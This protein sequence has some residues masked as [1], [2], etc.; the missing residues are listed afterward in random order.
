MSG[1][2]VVDTEFAEHQKVRKA[3]NAAIGLWV[4]AGSWCIR[5]RSNGFVPE[6]VALRLGTLLQA[7]RLVQTGLWIK[8]EAGFTYHDWVDFPH[9]PLQ[10]FAATCQ[11]GGE[12]GATHTQV[13]PPRSH[14]VTPQN[15]G[16]KQKQS[17][18]TPD[19]VPEDA[20][21]PNG[22]S[23]APRAR[24]LNT[25]SA[26][27]TDAERRAITRRAQALTDIYF[28]LEPLCNYKAVLGIVRRAVGAQRYSDKQ[29]EDALVRLA[30]NGMGVTANTLRIELNGA[31]AR[32]PLQAT[33][34]EKIRALDSLKSNNAIRF[35]NA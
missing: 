3:N 33:R 11:D 15:Q 24:G 5:N 9:G 1:F 2:F 23:A 10:N 7:E 6:R 14:P 35:A 21:N 22:F 12:G 30:E 26:D 16:Q 34:D 13:D 17:S 31:H 25:F 27:S 29:I 19:G 32:R 28:E 20:K 18:F 8:V 4:R